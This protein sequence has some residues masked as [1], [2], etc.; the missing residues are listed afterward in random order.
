MEADKSKSYRVGQQA[1][2]SKESQLVIQIKGYL[3]QNS[4][5]LRE[6]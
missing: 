4:L 2:D 1:R 3:L 5:W 6:N